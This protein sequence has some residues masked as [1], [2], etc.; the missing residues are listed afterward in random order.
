MGGGFFICLEGI[1]ACG[2]TTQARLLADFLKRRGY[3]AVYT[4]EPTRGPVG[5]MIRRLLSSES[6]PP[7]VVEAVLFAADRLSHVKGVIEP[8]LKAGRV[9]VC[10]R[11]YYSSIAYQGSAGLD[12]DWIRRINSFAPKPNLAIYLDVSPETALSRLGESKTVME[13]LDVQKAVRQVYLSLVR[14]GELVI[15]D[16]ERPVREVFEDVKKL[17]LKLIEG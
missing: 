1:D 12:V 4:T 17:A 8:S 11:Y 5:Q 3:P 2:K 10:D 16:G 9:L 6:R 15:V 14:E 7:P 13:R